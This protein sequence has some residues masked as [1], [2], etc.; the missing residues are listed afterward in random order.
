MKANWGNENTKPFY[1]INDKDNVYK[2]LM[3]SNMILENNKK[4]Y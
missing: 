2:S 3:E 1:D 4:V